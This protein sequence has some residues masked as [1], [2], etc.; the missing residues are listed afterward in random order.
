MPSLCH[1]KD[2]LEI[3]VRDNPIKVI[4]HWNWDQLK[5]TLNQQLDFETE[6]SIAFNK[7]MQER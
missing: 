2:L 5:N 1:S 7:F 6:S 3:R 4:R